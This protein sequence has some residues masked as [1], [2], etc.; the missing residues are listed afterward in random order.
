MR[1]PATLTIDEMPESE[2]PKRSFLAKTAPPA[3]QPAP[4]PP[5]PPLDPGIS[6]ADWKIFKQLLFDALFP[7]PEARAA[8]N[9]AFAKMR[10]TLEAGQGAPSTGGPAFEP[11]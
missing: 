5:P 6:V 7:F 4:E 8:V 9:A 10:Q 1:Y 11:A 3:P 2:R